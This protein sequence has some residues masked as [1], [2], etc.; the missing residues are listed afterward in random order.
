MKNQNKLQTLKGF[1]DFLP[2]EKRKRDFVMRRIVEIFEIFGFEPLET[3]TL[4]YAS[5]LIGKYG[6]EADK[7][8]YSFKDRGG[9]EIALRYDQTV[10]TARILTQYQ[11][12]LPRYF[13][14][15]QI[16]S[17][18][19]ADNPQKGR[20][21]EFTQCDIDIFNSE[22]PIADADIIATS[23]FAFKN[24]GYPDIKI[25]I[26]DRQ[27]LFSCLK[28]FTTP[29]VNIFSLIQSID[30]LEKIGKDQVI[31]E[32]VKKGLNK[33]KASAAISNIL[34]AKIISNLQNIIDMVYDLGV[35][36]KSIIFNPTLARG[37]DYYTGMIFEV[38]LPG[39]SVG[40]CGG[41][42][43]YDK[44]IGQLGGLDVPAVGIA[45][46][47]D[48][49]VEAADYFKLIPQT[50]YDIRALVTVFDKDSLPISLAITSTLR[51][52]RV[53][54]E[55]YPVF[56]KLSKQLKYADK[57]EIPYVVII[58]PEE[59]AQNVVKIKDMKTGD[60]KTLTIEDSIQ[61]LITRMNYN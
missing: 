30:K 18:F 54:T 57:K 40:S 37:L 29:H 14:R 56:D 45:F 2:E 55:I 23:Y 7:L 49:M 10:P 48:R 33:D 8:I 50:K 28:S 52:N 21:R 38:I 3:P 36:K 60:E 1:R 31:A 51:K 39:Y 35:P 17:V 6:Q 46:G 53:Q 20:Y 16:Q 27:I 47:F 11:N 19:R 42:G 4:E 34:K 13:R 25:Q 43:R 32:M 44:L 26:N 15:Y 58:G 61:Y 12:I 22:S 9:R 5:L 24:V 59:M 41:G